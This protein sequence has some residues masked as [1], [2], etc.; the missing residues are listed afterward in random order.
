[1]SYACTSPY[2]SA[3]SCDSLFIFLLRFD[4]FDLTRRCDEDYLVTDIVVIYVLLRPSWLNF[5]WFW[6]IYSLCGPYLRG[7]ILPLREL[8]LEFA[9]SCLVWRTVCIWF[10]G[11]VGTTIRSSFCDVVVG[12]YSLLSM[13]WLAFLPILGLLLDLDLLLLFVTWRLT[14]RTKPLVRVFKS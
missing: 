9:D 1:M 13:P 6:K 7:T 5:Y 4:E 12:I 2:R 3:R 8:C 11:G 10:V 14:E